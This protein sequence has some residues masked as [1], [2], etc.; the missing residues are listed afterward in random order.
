MWLQRADH[1]IVA[2]GSCY[3]YPDAVET[4]QEAAFLPG[5]PT[6]HSNPSVWYSETPGDSGSFVFTST[7][8]R[9]PSGIGGWYAT[10]SEVKAFGAVALWIQY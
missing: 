8:F 9:F 10:A 7:N 3:Y 1:V 4:P 5:C 2:S 6:A